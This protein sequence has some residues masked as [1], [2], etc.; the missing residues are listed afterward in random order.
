M[1]QLTI[2]SHTEHY[3]TENGELVGFGATVTEINHLL[4]VFDNIVHVAVLHD[5][6][7][8]D[9]ALPYVSNQITFVA[10]PVVGGKTITDKA[11]VI[12]KAPRILYIINKAL[13]VLECM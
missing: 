12:L 3:R 2:I 1:K 13:R 5:G 6:M 9:S 8:P 7:A 4:E 11:D 10:L